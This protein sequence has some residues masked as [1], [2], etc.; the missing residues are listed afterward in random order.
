MLGA[1][2]VFITGAASYTCNGI[3]REALWS[4]VRTSRAY[5]HG[6]RYR[7]A[8]FPDWST[9]SRSTHRLADHILAAIDKDL[10]ELLAEVGTCN[11]TCGIALGSAYGHLRPYFEY[12]RTAT[13]QGYQAVNPRFFPSTLPNACAVEINNAYSLFGCSTAIASGLS[14]GLEAVAYAG[15]VVANGKEATML[16]GGADEI[17]EFNLTI[18]ERMCRVS[19]SSHIRPF[20]ADRD[21]TAAGEAVA[22]VAIQ[23]QPVLDGRSPFAE[24][25]GFATTHFEGWNSPRAS[26]K[27]AAAIGRALRSASVQAAD[28]DIV[29]PSASGSLEGDEFELK[30]LERIF[31]TRLAQIHIVSVKAAVGECF[32]ASGPAQLVALLAPEYADSGFALVYSAG[33]DGTFAAVIIR[34]TNQHAI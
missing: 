34:R 16:A 21:G 5:L 9:R 8:A 7:F 11:K 32:A 6:T 12:Y 28:I 2:R 26:D 4:A 10:V 33:Y 29:F 25:C 31:G 15:N 22:I 19:S 30:L 18:V 13:R 14:A 1:S 24:I 20:A 23:P 17:N 27:V 3:G